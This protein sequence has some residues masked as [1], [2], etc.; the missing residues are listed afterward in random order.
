MLEP[1]L[2]HL[3]GSEEVAAIEDHRIRDLA[4]GKENAL[5][6]GELKGGAM[7][8][9]KVTSKSQ[10][11]IPAGVRDALEIRPGDHLAYDLRKGY[12]I[13]RPVHRT[14]A[15]GDPALRPFLDFL[16][17]DMARRPDALVPVTSDLAERIRNLVGEG[18]FDPDVPIEGDV[19]L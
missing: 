17:E 10:T 15:G 19:G 8:T 9:S 4:P 2:L 7:I 13:V 11:T 12:V 14:A 3:L 6:S 18:D 1:Q 16:A 5:P